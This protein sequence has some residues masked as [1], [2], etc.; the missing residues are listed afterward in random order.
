MKHRPKSN[1]WEQRRQLE[2]SHSGKSLMP[3]VVGGRGWVKLSKHR[4]C[5][6]AVWQ[7]KPR[8]ATEETKPDLAA[9]LGVSAHLIARSFIPASSRERRTSLSADDQHPRVAFPYQ[10]HLVCSTSH[11][12]HDRQ[13]GHRRNTRQHACPAQLW[14]RDTW[15]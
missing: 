5:V 3:S 8:A 7:S 1:G 2:R 4:Q 14:E 9:R 12:W 11:H 10:T 13:S 6:S 15:R